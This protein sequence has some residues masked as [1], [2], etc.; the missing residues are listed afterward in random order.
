M[1]VIRDIAELSKLTDLCYGNHTLFEKRRLVV[2]LI[3]NLNGDFSGYWVGRKKDVLFS[4]IDK[5][6][7]SM[8]TYA[9]GNLK[10]EEYHLIQREINDLRDTIKAAIN[11]QLL[12]L[13]A[14]RGI[15]TCYLSDLNNSQGKYT[16]MCPTQKLCLVK[17][18]E[19]VFKKSDAPDVD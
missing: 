17:V 18:S 14:T 6:H 5:L 9:R 8:L 4:D 11:G 3:S 10:A 2:Q 12:A 1:T 13:E 16:R 7:E 15:L 19:G